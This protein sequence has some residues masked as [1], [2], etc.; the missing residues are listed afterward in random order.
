MEVYELLKKEAPEA[1]DAVR[2]L[3]A[4]YPD[5][6]LVCF[7]FERVESGLNTSLVVMDDK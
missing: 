2:K 6:P 3:H 7:H 1:S 5:D 4:E